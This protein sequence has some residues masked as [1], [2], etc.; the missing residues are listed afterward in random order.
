[1][2]TACP[3]SS[4]PTARH[5]CASKGIRARTDWNR[6]FRNRG[7]LR[8]EDVTEKAGVR[9]EGYA[10]GAAA[11]DYDND[12]RVDLFVAGVQRNSC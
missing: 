8:F 3:T 6:L 2:A 1:M 7:G 12:G 11:G 5:A 9:G 4:S 10:T